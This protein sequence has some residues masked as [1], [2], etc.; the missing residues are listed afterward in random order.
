MTSATAPS[1]VATESTAYPGVTPALKAWNAMMPR[2]GAQYYGSGWLTTINSLPAWIGYQFAS[3]TTV[4]RYGFQPWWEDDYPGRCPKNWVLQGSS[5]GSSW[6]DL[7]TI[8]GFVPTSSTKMNT[9]PIS[10][11]ASYAYY[12]MYITVNNGSAYT[13]IGQFQLYVAR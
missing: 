13:G 6:D 8:T 3:A 9:F 12:R 2:K 11:P 4:V 1:G 7:D 5:D 10:S